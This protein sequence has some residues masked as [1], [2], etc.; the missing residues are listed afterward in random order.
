MIAAINLNLHGITASTTTAAATV[1]TCIACIGWNL[2]SL[3]FRSQK[4]SPLQRSLNKLFEYF[5][6]FLYEIEYLRVILVQLIYGNVLIG[7]VK[8]Q[9]FQREY[10]LIQC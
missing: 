8:K 7:A 5:R 9:E 2:I 1:S 6:V 4:E 10:D 3:P